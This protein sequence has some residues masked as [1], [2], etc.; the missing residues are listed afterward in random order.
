MCT[1]QPWKRDARW[2]PSSLEDRVRTATELEY[3]VALNLEYDSCPLQR[4]FGYILLPLLVDYSTHEAHLA[5]NLRYN[6]PVALIPNE[7]VDVG[8]SIQPT[9]AL[10]R[11]RRATD[12][13]LDSV[14][15]RSGGAWLVTN[16]GSVEHAGQVMVA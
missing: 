15:S 7:R 14:K 10:R 2:N 12:Q 1:L 8:R 16:K 4:T 9:E 11:L 5:H 3:P 6:N 13:P